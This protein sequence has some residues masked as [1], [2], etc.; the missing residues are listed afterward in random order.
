MYNITIEKAAFKYISRLDKTTA[1]RV[2]NA[3]DEIAA[4]PKIGKHLSNHEASYSYRI[5]DYRVL[6]D[7]YESQVLVVVV[8]V[9]GRGDVYKR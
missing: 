2:R 9:K 4:D 5:G 1:R 8:K 3:I 6:Y 7:I